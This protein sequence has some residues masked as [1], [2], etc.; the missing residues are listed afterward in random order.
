MLISHDE[1]VRS[2]R[3]EQLPSW[4]IWQEIDRRM[5]QFPRAE[6]GNVNDRQILSFS[7]Y[8]DVLNV[9]KRVAELLRQAA[10]SHEI[11]NRVYQRIPPGR[12]FKGLVDHLKGQR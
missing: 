1:L 11:L 5:K 10:T 9:D 3:K 6:I 2:V 8:I 7:P 4:L 12:G